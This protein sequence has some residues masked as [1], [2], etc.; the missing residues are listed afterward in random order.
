RAALAYAVEHNNVDEVKALL[1]VLP[2]DITGSETETQRALS[3]A[4]SY[5][6]AYIV[7]L[8]LQRAD[9]NPTIENIRRR[10]LLTT[11]VADGYVAIVK[12]LIENGGVDPNA[13]DI[14][15]RT[16]LMWAVRK[17]GPKVEDVRSEC[18]PD[19]WSTFRFL[20]NFDD[21]DVNVRDNHGRTALCHAAMI[22]TQRCVQWLVLHPSIRPHLPDNNGRTALSFAAERG[23]A[24]ITG[25]LLDLQLHEEF[26]LGLRDETGRTPL[27]R[28]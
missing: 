24:D 14:E 8:L 11:A 25:M 5:G 28:A 2:I 4:I 3:L 21:I 9:V 26:C 7:E 6:H 15:G 1:Q 12:L 20:L 18:L 17:L 16:P 10:T 19:H 22:G 23:Y 13:V 27:S